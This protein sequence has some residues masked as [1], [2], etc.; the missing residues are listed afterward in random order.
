MNGWVMDG[1]MNAWMDGWRGWVD[2]HP[3]RKSV[4]SPWLHSLYQWY[5]KFPVLSHIMTRALV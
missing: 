3:L 1:R 5:F 2:C 4:N